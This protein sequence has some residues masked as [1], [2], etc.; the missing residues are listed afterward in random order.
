MFE[1]CSTSDSKCNFIRHTHRLFKQ[2]P[3]VLLTRHFQLVQSLVFSIC[4]S[5]LR[6]YFGCCCHEDCFA[7]RRKNKVFYPKDVFYVSNNNYISCCELPGYSL[8]SVCS[9]DLTLQ[10]LL[11]FLAV[12][13]KKTK[14]NLLIYY[15]V[16][17]K[18]CQR[19]LNSVKDY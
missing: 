3:K 8:L 5:C 7:S 15:L 18:I 9:Y 16:Y 2:V 12:K 14:Q 4:L 13:A 6:R 1:S 19:T 11:S 10:K 17:T